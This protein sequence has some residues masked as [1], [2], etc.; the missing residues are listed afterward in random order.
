[1]PEKGQRVQFAL[2]FVLSKKPL[3]ISALR[4]SVCGAKAAAETDVLLQIILRFIRPRAANAWE[5][6]GVR[7]KGMLQEGQQ[8]REQTQEAGPMSL[9]RRALD[10]ITEVPSER[11]IIK[12]EGHALTNA[13]T[14]A[15][16]LELDLQVE[17]KFFPTQ[18]AQA[19][20]ALHLAAGADVH[21]LVSRH[22]HGAQGHP[23]EP[24]RARDHQEL[25][26]S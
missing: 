4:G 25:E 3:P 13:N 19:N 15:V 2:P 8:S 6:L 16:A 1:M 7:P 18:Q 20:A 26:V 24:A 21:R 12:H 17:N 22:L 23:A 14:T 9:E 11:A 5:Q 10:Q